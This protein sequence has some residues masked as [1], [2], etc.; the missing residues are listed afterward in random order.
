MCSSDL[1]KRDTAPESDGQQNRPIDHE[2]CGDCK[3]LLK[4]CVRIGCSRRP[5]GFDL[6][7]AN[8]HPAVGEDE[9]LN[10]GD[11][12]KEER[13]PAEVD[14]G[15]PPGDGVREH[16]REDGDTSTGI[17]NGRNS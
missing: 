12:M 1:D 4:L 5:K 8:R 17:E 15:L 7:N 2:K 16:R 11:E 3:G 13:K 9:H 10:N 6:A 14:A